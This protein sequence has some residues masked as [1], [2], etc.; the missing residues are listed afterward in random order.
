MR[1]DTSSADPTAAEKDGAADPLLAQEPARLV[2]ARGHCLHLVETRHQ[3]GQLDRV[4][5]WAQGRISTP[6]APAA[7]EAFDPPS[8]SE[9]GR[10][11]RGNAR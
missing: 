6:P 8:A 4:G 5:P 11:A 9:A 3:D 1:S 7:A 2:D 10:R